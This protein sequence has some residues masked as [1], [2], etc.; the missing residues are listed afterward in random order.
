[1]KLHYGILILSYKHARLF[2]DTRMAAK[3]LNKLIAFRIAQVKDL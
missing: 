2:P 3:E 1:M